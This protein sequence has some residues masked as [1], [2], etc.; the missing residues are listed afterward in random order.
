MF[1]ATLPFIVKLKAADAKGVAL[2]LDE[3]FRERGSVIEL[4]L[5]NSVCFRYNCIKEIA[6]KWSICCTFICA[7]ILSGNEIVERNH[8]TIKR[9]AA[10][11][12]ADPLDIVQ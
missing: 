9:L 5:D 10:R 12:D 8:R 7:Y 2:I 6:K 4:L 3:I 11:S 1:V